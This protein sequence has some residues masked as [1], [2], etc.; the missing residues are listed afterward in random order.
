MTVGSALLFI[1][2]KNG[3]ELI[4]IKKKKSKK[5]RINLIWPINKRK[6][7]SLNKRNGKMLSEIEN[8]E[9]VFR[10]HPN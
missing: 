10:P 5:R 8:F 3:K 2:I 9:I 7:L 1:V 6:L 4:S